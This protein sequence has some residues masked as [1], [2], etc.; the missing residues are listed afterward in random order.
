V[1]I[2]QGLD[3][4]ERDA[5]GHYK[6]PPREIPAALLEAGADKEARDKAGLTALQVW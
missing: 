6:Y 4:N 2:S 1:A 3:L 5:N